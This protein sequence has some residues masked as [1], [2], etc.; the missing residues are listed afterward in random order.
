M[1]FEIDGLDAMLELPLRA[2]PEAAWRHSGR[3]SPPPISDFSAARSLSLSFPSVGRLCRLVWPIPS[4]TILKK[5]SAEKADL[6]KQKLTRFAAM[7]PGTEAANPPEPDPAN[8]S[9]SSRSNFVALDRGEI[10]AGLV[11]LP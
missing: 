10:R 7:R 5:E 1:R 3:G 9:G 4:W 8:R 2:V 6:D 11:S